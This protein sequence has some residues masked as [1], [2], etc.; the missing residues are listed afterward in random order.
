MKISFDKVKTILIAFLLISTVTI[1]VFAIPQAD[2]HT[3]PWQITTYA[4]I[5]AAPDPVGVG[6]QTLIF[7]WLDNTIQGVAIDNSIRFRNYQLTITKPD[8]TNETKS[9]PIVTDPTSSAYTPYVPDQI[10]NYTLTF[11]FPGQIYDYGTQYPLN[12]AY[13][14]DTYTA[15][16]ATTT[17]TVQQQP[18]AKIPEYP[19]PTEYWTRPIEGENHAWASIGSNWLGGAAVTDIWQKNGAAPRSAHVMWSKSIELGGLT[20]DVIAQTGDGANDTAMTWYSG[21]SYNTRFGNPIILGGT[22]YYQAPLGE[23]GTGGG[24]FAVDLRTGQQLWTSDTIIP[25]KAQ[26]YDLQTP[27]QHGVVGS[28]LWV[29]SGSTWSA[30]NAFNEKFLFNLTNVPSGTEVYTNDGSIV[31][32]IFSYNSTAKTV[33]LALWNNTAVITNGA[34][35]YGGPGWPN[36]ATTTTF[37]ANTANSYTYNVTTTADLSGFQAPAIVGVIPGD[38]ILGSSSAVSLTSLPRPN[39]DPWTMWAISDKPENRGTLLWI[40]NYSAPAGNITRML[41]WQPID[42]ITRAWTMTDFETGQRLAYSLDSGNLLWGP[43]GQQPG[44]QYY[45]SREGLPAYGNLYVTGYG[46]VVYCFSMSNGTLLWTY[47]NGGAGN[48]TNSGDETPWG[49]Y[50]THAA[51]FADGI[52]YTMSGEH[53][54]NTPLYKGYRARAIDAFTGKELWT[55]LDWS[56]SGLGTSVAPIA[57]ADGYMVFANAYDGQVYCVG[58]G[59]SATTMAIQNNVIPQGNSILLQGAVTDIAAGTQQAGVAARF[60]NGVPAVSDASQ[61]AWMEYVYM[62]KPRPSNATGVMV[63]FTAIDPNGNTRDLGTATSDSTG[64]FAKLFT[65]DVS[66]TYT[67]TAAFFGSDSYWPSYT[68]TAFAVTQGPTPAPT[69]TPQPGT[70]TDMYVLGS[71]IAIIIAVAI[72]GA[73]IMLMLRRRP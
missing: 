17:L 38:L 14:N 59:P 53:S 42:P 39:S 69:A 27:N 49:R 50:P 20:G 4:Y 3:P 21:F 33:N 40:K 34:P 57:I 56:A 15:S 45:S 44:F 18:V 70:N 66:G 24:E 5:T 30:Y 60:P 62:Q 26:L 23:M 43:V 61:T 52:L 32:Y 8:G 9:W 68:E 54:P 46:G 11:N 22:L 36:N 25:S 6:Q 51:G 55:L 28:M 72:V 31:R 71:A 58:K 13:N 64:A 41:A 12:A 67:V 7:V 2:A 16:S 35:L 47:G 65:P 19:L 10:G 48:S 63:S 1:T 73:L 37:N 29:V